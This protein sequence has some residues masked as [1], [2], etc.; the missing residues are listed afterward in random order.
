M[1]ILKTKYNWL[2]ES[3][4]RIDASYHLSD[5]PLT[6]IK[7][8]KSPYEMTKLR[9]ETSSIFKGNIFKR[10]YVNTSE[11]GYPF[12]TASDIMKPEVKVN[13]FISK[14]Y[15][16]QIDKLILKKDWI[17]LT[18]SGTLGN[19]IFTT[20]DFEGIV[21]TDDL[22]RIIPK[23]D[24]IKKGFLY[25][26]LASK[27]GYG[28]ITQSGYG[29]VVKH[30]EPHHIEDLPIPI[31]TPK[32]QIQIHNYIMETSRLRVEANREIKTLQDE[33]IIKLSKFKDD[34]FTKYGTT[35]SNKVLLKEKRFDASYYISE[36]R[37]I[38]NN[39]VK[40]NYKLLSSISEIFHPM[41]FGKKQLKGTPVKG[42]PLFKSSSMMKLFPETDF[43]LSLRKEIKY[44]KL[45]VK[46]DWVLISRTGTVGNVVAISKELSGIYIDDHMIRVI[47]KENYS[48][49]IY[50]YLTTL[51]GKSLITSQKYGSVQDVINSDYIG[52]I[53]VPKELLSDDYLERT[54]V[55]VKSAFNKKDKANLLEKKAIKLIE[56]EIESWQL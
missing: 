26:Y 20:E 30:I 9:N 36:G 55:G 31:F 18:R 22:I 7:F 54:R 48:G 43:W 53:P 37:L 10:T 33:I 3:G 38:H 6:K 29:G 44:S 12:M 40:G 2:K 42:N 15:T 46:E 25:A 56:N 21:G 51:F 24:K 39:I 52:R 28:L 13:K 23:E 4:W 41:L 17:L 14:K 50:L 11:N 49:I 5:G 8:K 32:K 19:S 16:N 45:K 47:P 35:Y 27:Y 1:K 34:S